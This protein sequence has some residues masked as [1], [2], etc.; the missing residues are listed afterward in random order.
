MYIYNC[1]EFPFFIY[2]FITDNIRM[3][4]Y[5]ILP[6]YDNYYQPIIMSLIPTERGSL[7][8]IKTRTTV[9]VYFV[10][11]LTRKYGKC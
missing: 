3:L 8:E 6:E 10:V 2:F 11:A 5:Q 7:K 9:K 1:L 4:N